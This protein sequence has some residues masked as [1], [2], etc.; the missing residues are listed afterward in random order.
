M[1]T[2]MKHAY[3][4]MIIH[5]YMYIYH[6]FYVFVVSNGFRAH[7]HSPRPSRSLKLS[8]VILQPCLG[9]ITNKKPMGV[10][11]CPWEHS[12]TNLGSPLGLLSDLQAVLLE[13]CRIVGS[14]FGA[15]Y[16]AFCSLVNLSCFLGLSC[17][18]L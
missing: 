8:R 13:R 4:S 10:L 1:Y 6:A 5:I 12:P 7:W 15:A 16:W 17:D 9:H 2:Y 14:R 18:I 11:G 3:M